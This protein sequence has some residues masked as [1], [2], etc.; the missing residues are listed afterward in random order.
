MNVL[1]SLYRV[2]G[3]ARCLPHVAQ[4]ILAGSAK[5]VDLVSELVMELVRYNPKA[6]IKLYLTGVFFFALQYGGS[7]WAG[8]AKLLHSTHLEQ[9]FYHDAASLASETT[10][11]K[12][13]FLGTMLPEALVCVL[14]NRG[15]SAFSESFLGDC[16]TPEVIWKYSMRQHLQDMLRQHI[17]D[18][19]SRLAANPSTLYDFC[20]VPPVVYEELEE[21]LWCHN[22]Y[23]RNLTDAE[24]FPDWYVT[25]SPWHRVTGLPLSSLFS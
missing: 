17:G 23:L 9:S 25:T 22:F 12:R 4:A 5:L 10:L 7:N 20:P 15:P 3:S 21:E 16:D 6:M 18:L 19:P 24:R 14:A 13:S 1:A 11:G 8:L 2:L